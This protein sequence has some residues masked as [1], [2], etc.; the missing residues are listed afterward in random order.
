MINNWIPIAIVSLGIIVYTV[1][2]L[3]YG[4]IPTAKCEELFEE[5]FYRATGYR[6]QETAYDCGMV[7][8]HG[9]LNW[10][11][12]AAL[13]IFT[14]VASVAAGIIITVALRT[15][16]KLKTISAESQ[17]MANQQKKIFTLLIFQV[18]PLPETWI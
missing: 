2:A 18:K 1:G 15:T 6:I 10:I 13:G 17:A 5:A 12:F 11:L 4:L 8:Y 3:V 9:Q 7:F 14:V 16:R